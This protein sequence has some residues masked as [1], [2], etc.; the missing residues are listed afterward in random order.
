MY[1]CT[2]SQEIGHGKTYAACILWHLGGTSWKSPVK[3][4]IAMTLSF[5]QGREGFKH[6]S[7]KMHN[8][9]F[10]LPHFLFLMLI[11]EKQVHYNDVSATSKANLHDDTSILPLFFVT[12]HLRSNTKIYV[13][14]V[15]SEIDTICS[16]LSCLLQSRATKRGVRRKP[17]I[18]IKPIPP[19]SSFRCTPQSI[20]AFEGF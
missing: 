5:E 7:F 1:L 6:I 15:W 14:C 9:L 18:M 12:C 4:G 20:C 10:Q 3:L 17:N 19:I 11:H 16:L 8:L 13:R 2:D